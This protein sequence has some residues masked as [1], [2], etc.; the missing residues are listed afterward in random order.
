[1]D[2][3]QD[4]IVRTQMRFSDFRFRGDD[5]EA[6]R[7]R[8]IKRK[9]QTLH[10]LELM[11]VT[12]YAFQI[13][14][15]PSELNR[16]LVSAKCNEMTH[17]QDFNVKLYEYGFRPFKLRWIWWFVGLIFGLGSRLLGTKMILKAG[18]WV[19]KKAVHHYDK[20]LKIEWDDKTREI[21]RKNRHDEE[22]HIEHWTDL[23]RQNT[24]DHTK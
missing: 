12:I 20:L 2:E 8:Q 23:L 1:M 4:Y 6:Q 18:I 11:A 17:Y 19:E 9:L 5:M 13:T 15:N 16:Q 21:I 24:C 22:I 7:L 10:N 14:K 3:K